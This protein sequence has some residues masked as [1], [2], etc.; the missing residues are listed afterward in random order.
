[1]RKLP[2]VD[3][4]KDG[5]GVWVFTGYDRSPGEGEWPAYSPSFPRIGEQDG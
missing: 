3:Q 5:R 4:V 2:G 1:M